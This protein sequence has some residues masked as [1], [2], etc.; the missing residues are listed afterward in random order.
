MPIF[1]Y[2]I[3]N[4]N[5]I[6]AHIYIMNPIFIHPGTFDFEYMHEILNLDFYAIAY[7]PMNKIAKCVI[8]IVFFLIYFIL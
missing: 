8:F 6:F 4:E 2:V 1:Q 7:S 5:Y 3:Q